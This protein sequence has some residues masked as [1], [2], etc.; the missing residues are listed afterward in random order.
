MKIQFESDLNYQNN[1]INS[2]VNIFEGQETCQSNFS[3]SKIND[4]LFHGT[5]NELGIGN[6]LELLDDELL[7][8]IQNIQLKNGLPQSKKLN[9]MDFSVEMETGTGK[10]YVYLKSIFEMNKK[11]GFTKFIIVVPSI[12]IKEGT[13]KTLDITTEH[14]KGIFDNVNYDHFIYDSSNLEQVRDFAT[15][16][17]I[18]IMVINIDAFKKSFTDPTKDTKANI[19][20]RPN[21]RLNGQ[22]PIEFIASTNP[23]VI[24]D[25]PQSVDNTTKSKEAIST[26]NPLCRLRYS[27][28]HIDKHNLMYKLDSIDAYEQKLVKQIEVANVKLDEDQNN[29]YIKVISIKANPRSAK[30]EIDVNTNGKTSR[31][32]ITINSK[33]DLYESSKGRDV[34]DGY[35][36]NDIYIE[37]NNECIE[38]GNGI[39]VKL[40]GVVGDIDGDSIKRLQLRKTIEEHL[41]KELRLNSKGIKVLS[42]FFLDR[43]SNYRQYD[44]NKNP[45]NGKFADWFEEE[46]LTISKKVKYKTLFNDTKNFDDNV[47]T[48]HNGY[49]SRDKKGIVKDSSSNA[50][51]E[52]KGNKD[53]EDT[54]SLI[55]KDKEKL[56]SFESP[57]R[58]IFSHSALKEGWDNPNVFQICTLNET[59]SVM[60]K[61]QEIGR[62]LR[63]CVNQAGERVQGFDVNTLTVMANES[64]EDFAKGLQE[65]IEKE[66]GI[67]FGVIE[68]HYFA[69]ITIE[70]ENGDL[71]YFGV[72]NSENVY[73]YL[74]EKKYIDKKGKVQNSLKL[75]IKEN[76]FEIP[77]EYE[78]LKDKITSNIIKIAGT[79]IVKDANDKIIIKLNKEAFIG[80]DFKELWGKIKYKTNY[81]VDFDIEELINTCAK[82]IEDEVTVGK[83]KYLYTKATNQIIKVGVEIDKE[84]LK[85]QYIDSEIINYKLPDI[86]TYLQNETKLMRKNIVDVLIK[87]NKLQSFK[88]NPQKFIDKVIE[89]IKKTMS[90]FIVDGIKYQKI[91]D[92][93]Y[94]AQECFEETELSGY[95]STNLI[96]NKNNK[97]V[98]DYTIYDSDIEK[99]FAKKFNDS[100]NVKLFTKLPSWFKINTPL[101]GYNPD[102][103]VLIEKDNQEKLYFV[104]ESKGSNL[105]LDIKNTE[106]AKIDCGI[107]HFKATSQDIKFVQSDSFENFKE[108]F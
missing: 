54:F 17:D 92:E 18:R 90:I 27:A 52:L 96:K 35:I 50:K 62:G 31:K 76:N 33:S 61:R 99:S 19:I 100:E 12:A 4:N 56:L 1:A 16:S 106:K 94:Y 83:I 72:K 102:W 101:G 55:M 79:N 36:V 29:A 37:E 57:L 84:S 70:K 91:G 8:N 89:I 81:R 42:L 28:T 69:N 103:A 71:E 65:E 60:K 53:D 6:R 38:F 82:K 47:K 20:H 30:V 95:L 77:V 40:K 85:E 10:T 104:V 14:F 87:S 58:F 5:G 23:I 93:F 48:I 21:D 98:Y 3:V 25:E 15:S 24:I 63:I 74:L 46:Y 78:N 32:S 64:Y 49:F 51:G 39:V 13:K 80:E 66:E 45:I 108:H 43:V 68:E 26:L 105:S 2:I 67:K 22:K 107:Q 34:Y 88:N 59:N 9:S 97:S 44:E 86:I 73:N 7:T 11:Y 41:D 75:D